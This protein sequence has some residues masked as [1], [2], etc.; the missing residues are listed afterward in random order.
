MY[1][2][3]FE[4][5]RA[6]SVEEA[7]GLLARH[8]DDAKLLA[9]GHSLVPTM[10]LRLAQPKHLV[11]IGRIAGLAG[12]REEGAHLVLGA[13]TTHHAIE[14]SALLAGRCPVLAEAAALIGDPQVRNW[15]TLGGSLAHAD[16]AADWPAVVLAL[17]AELRLVGPRGTRTVTADGF[18]TDLMTTALRPD[19]MLTEIRIPVPGPRT[20]TAYL[21]HPHPASRFAVVGVAAVVALEP[22]GSCRQV[23]VAITGAGSHAVRARGVEAALAGKV[24]D[25]GAIAAAAEHGAE[26]VDVN[27]D[28]Q[29]SEEYKAHLV[30]VYVRRALERAAAR[31]AGSR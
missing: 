24:P 4:Y 25:A 8:K 6:A 5:H 7:V 11:D 3:S 31:A 18:F 26:G 14:S 10:K 16:P 2:A 22:S 23:R 12:I 17:D 19:E 13:L 30:R 27:A 1:P 9:G 20:G 21:K 15:G 28:L 29:G